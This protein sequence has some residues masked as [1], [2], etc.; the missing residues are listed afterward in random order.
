MSEYN[1][2]FGEGF[3]VGLAGGGGGSGAEVY[4]GENEPSSSGIKI[5]IDTSSAEELT[6]IQITGPSGVVAG[7][8]ITLSAV[9][10]PSG[11]SLAGAVYQWTAASGGSAVS[12]SGTS[13]G[14]CTVT[15]VSAGNAVIKCMATVGGMSYEATASVAVTAQPV[16]PTGIALSANAAT[17]RVNKTYSLSASVIP[18]GATYTSAT[19]VFTVESGGEYVAIAQNGASCTV[20]G[21]A[22][23]SAVIKCVGTVDGTVFAAVSCAITV[24]VGGLLPEDYTQ[25]NYVQ[26]DGVDDYV[27]TGIY[28]GADHKV[29]G[30]KVL[31]SCDD[32]SSETAKT[33]VSAH[34]GSYTRRIV[35]QAKSGLVYGGG[36]SLG[37]EE[38]QYSVPASGYENKYVFE[39]N[40]LNDGKKKAG[41]ESSLT[42]LENYMKPGSEIDRNVYVFANNEHVSGVKECGN[43]RVY[44]LEITKNNTVIGKF[45]PCR[46]PQNVVGF[47]DIISDTFHGNS[48]TGELI[49]G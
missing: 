48:G 1:R 41:T 33:I 8:Q 39:L 34:Q 16:L 4:I 18:S 28:V 40:Y 23:G 30:C 15:G 49:G 35:L 46:N 3:V 13:G 6:G 25:L 11:A 17:V 14:S 29:T 37:T 19:Y 5:W 31:F 24:V 27:D 32:Y 47:Y 42:V 45:I 43:F 12:L 26:A 21:I 22:E 7:A 9:P 36:S 10:V 38:T 20:T 44:E 2:G